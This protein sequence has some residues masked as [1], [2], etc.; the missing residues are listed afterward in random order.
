MKTAERLIQFEKFFGTPFT[1]TA[2]YTDDPMAKLYLELEN[3]TN[4]RIW[5]TTIT[6][7]MAD[8]LKSGLVNKLNPKLIFDILSDFNEGKLDTDR[9]NILFPTDE[10][11]EYEIILKFEFK[12]SVY[13]SVINNHITI[14]LVEK[15]TT[16]EERTNKKI[17]ATNL[18][19]EQKLL[20]LIAELENKIKEIDANVTSM[21][22]NLVNVID[23]GIN[24]IGD[25]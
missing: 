20:G 10:Q 13:K 25:K 16:A 17:I 24:T 7:G 19:L 5:T 9:V 11:D 2:K 21:K 23:V 8:L 22:L 1:F 4:Y 18:L 12:T 6:N 15:E 3:N 14:S